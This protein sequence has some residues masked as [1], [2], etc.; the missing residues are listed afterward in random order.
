MKISTKA[1]VAI[2]AILDIAVHGK[3]GPVSLAD[4]GRRQRVSKSY[5]EYLFKILR[6]HG[7]VAG[8][9][10]P[11]GGY[12]LQRRLAEITVADIIAM[13]DGETFDRAAPQHGGQA[14]DDPTKVTDDL[15]RRVDEQLRKY[16]CSLTLESAL[17]TATEAE[18]LRERLAV[19]ATVPH[20]EVAQP[21]HEIPSAR[22]AA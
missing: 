19:V 7:I 4:I 17:A 11:G 16:L 20:I 2:A 14:S 12:L 21:R 10:G 6:Q 9:R 13:V 5:L 8:L 22:A 18:N 15:W 3:N 1:R